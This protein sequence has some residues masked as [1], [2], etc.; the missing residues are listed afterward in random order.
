MMKDTLMRMRRLFCLLLLLLGCETATAANGCVNGRG[1]LE[2]PLWDGY[3]L[4]I[5]ATDD[6]ANPCYA[7]VLAADGKAV[8]EIWGIDA[9][10]ESVTGRDVN[11]DGKPDVVLLTHTAS[12]PQNVYS[13][14]GTVE[15]PGLVKQIVTRAALSFED[16]QGDG[17]MEI[18]TR[19][20]SFREFDGLTPEQSPS[21]LV[22]LRLKGKEFF[23]VSNLY[24]PEYEREIQIARGKMGRD[25]IATFKGESTGG[26]G[27][28]KDPNKPKEETPEQLFHKQ[29]IKALILEI[30]VDNIYGG[31]GQEAWAALKEMWPYADR[32][33]IRQEILRAR[34]NGVLKDINRPAARQ[35][36]SQ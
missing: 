6:A 23:N 19:D 16:R 1:S 11:N 36:S 24:W 30:V 25:D 28:G 15:P 14:V 13:I 2:R 29:E 7:G 10:M 18:V 21:P 32:D 31:H 9:V 12:S 5:G 33:R 26:G 22:F 35:A 17:H 8:F 34:M 20:T 27:V 3:S 4:K